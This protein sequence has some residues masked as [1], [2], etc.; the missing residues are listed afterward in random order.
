MKQKIKRAEL[1]VGLT[2]LHDEKL[3]EVALEAA[4]T[5]V[6]EEESYPIAYMIRELCTR[7]RSK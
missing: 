4:D 2:L 1:A 5:L 6:G 3:V 7:V